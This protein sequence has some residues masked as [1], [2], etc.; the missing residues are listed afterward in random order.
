MRNFLIFSAV[1][2]IIT[3]S[4]LRADRRY[5]AR[6]Y[7][8]YTIPAKVLELEIWNTG[9]IQKDQG[10]YYKWQPRIEFEYGVTDK[11]TAAIYFNF[12]EIRSKNNL[13][14]PKSLSFTSTSYELRYRLFEI[15]EYF[16]D[17][18]L[19]AEFYYGGDKVKYEPKIFL[20]KRSANFI[21]VINF[22]SEIEKN[23]PMNSTKSEF[24]ITGGLA[25][26]IN[27]NFAAGLEFRNH[28]NFTNVY[29]KKVNQ[30]FFM[31]PTINF[32]T[33]KFYFTINLIAQING[34]STNN[35]RLD[36]I[37]HEK[38]EIRSILGIEL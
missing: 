15:G 34:T 13:Y 10:Y 20:T 33:E 2:I 26:E 14:P 11:L 28:L 5:F 8:S 12:E 9:K 29:D 7:T 22:N 18:T 36:L 27:A 35:S 17:P 38:Y 19:Y 25:Y 1:L 30:A 32:Q 23:I 16:I 4:V 24:E 3:S 6:S 21:G 31:G 37:G